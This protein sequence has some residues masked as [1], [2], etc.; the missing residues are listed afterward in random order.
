MP[1]GTGD[2]AG[3]GQTRGG[4]SRVRGG[5]KPVGQGAVHVAVQ[6]LARDGEPGPGPVHGGG[7]A[8]HGRVHAADADGLRHAHVLGQQR[9]RQADGAVRVPSDRGG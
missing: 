4:Q 7:P 1:A 2:G 3:R 9:V 5:G 6:Q 8:Q